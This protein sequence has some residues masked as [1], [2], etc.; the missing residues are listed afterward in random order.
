MFLDMN[1]V[2]W[3]SKN[4]IRE[5]AD[6]LLSDYEA[7]HEIPVEPPIP[8]ENIIETHLGFILEYEDLQGILGF[9]DILGATWLNQK[10]ITINEKLL[11][12]NLGRMF[13]T[14]GHEIG[15]VL[16]HSTCVSETEDDILHPYQEQK[17]VCRTT[18]AKKRGEWQADYFAACLLMPE[19]KVRKAYDHVFGTSPLIIHNEKSCFDKNLPLFDPAWDRAKDFALMVMEEGKFT[20]VSKEAMRVRLEDLGLLINNTHNQLAL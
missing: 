17:I 15:H 3:L 11:E 20:N 18:A 4:T 1:R 14:C 8:V 7:V 6:A 9:D 16:L 19:E 12:K 2:P 10:R 13:F 5:H